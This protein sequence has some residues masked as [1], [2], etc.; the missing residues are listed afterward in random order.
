MIL[1]LFIL[2]LCSVEI[3]HA[4]VRT[5]RDFVPDTD[6]STR[7]SPAE[8]QDALAVVSAAQIL[9]THMGNTNTAP[10]SCN[11]LSGI[12]QA[13]RA[14]GPSG[15][16]AYLKE[17]RSLFSEV[18]KLSKAGKIPSSRSTLQPNEIFDQV[19]EMFFYIKSVKG[20]NSQE[21][22]E[23]LPLIR[24]LRNDYE[25]SAKMLNNFSKDLPGQTLVRNEFLKS[26]NQ[27]FDD[28]RKLTEKI[29]R[30]PELKSY[31]AISQNAGTKS[32]KK[33]QAHYEEI[34]VKLM[35]S[36]LENSKKLESSPTQT[37]TDQTVYAS[38]ERLDLLRKVFQN[39]QLSRAISQNLQ[40]AN[41]TNRTRIETST[42]EM[43][44]DEE[45][46]NHLQQGGAHVKTH[47][48][49]RKYEGLKGR[50][51]SSMYTVQSS[52]ERLQII[53]SQLAL[54]NELKTD[55][56]SSLS[57]NS[58]SGISTTVNTEPGTPNTANETSESGSESRRESR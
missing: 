1:V 33:I 18:N 22:A 34:T 13:D 28:Y 50:R 51:R 19:N 20:E 32:Y 48:E 10:T 24:A 11:L 8:T 6:T 52:T 46:I 39:N 54:M 56:G 55:R 38:P 23:I 25:N 42:L 12:T 3:G 41:E 44:K 4:Q 26:A 17:T 16:E 53:Q 47:P 27:I 49:N 7:L 21:V 40:K 35:D 5:D 14:L 43:K 30:D 36:Y 45:E 37:A 29:D 31:F 58:I 2:T 57:T 9:S 15:L